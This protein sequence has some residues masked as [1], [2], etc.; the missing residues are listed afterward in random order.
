MSQ[1]PLPIVAIL[2]GTGKEGSGLAWRW[3]RNAYPLI[4]GSRLAERAVQSAKELA[5]KV[6][7]ANV[8]G[9]GNVEAAREGEI[10]VLTVPYEVQMAT[11]EGVKDQ[12]KGKILVDATA[13]VDWRRP[14]PPAGKA[15][16]RM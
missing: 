7:G 13:R 10:V 5:E 14:R 6:P 11:L 9:A 2:G 8:R 15:A 1:P 4:I 12:L 16:A 3:A